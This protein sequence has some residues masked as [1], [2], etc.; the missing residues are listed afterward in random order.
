MDRPMCHGPTSILKSYCV[1]LGIERCGFGQMTPQ[2]YRT[3]LVT[4]GD[5][6][7][8]ES[9]RTRLE[10][11]PPPWHASNIHRGSRR[12]GRK[13]GAAIEEFEIV[14]PAQQKRLLAQRD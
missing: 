10:D 9:N 14:D 4:N 3:C 12:D 11:L 2:G 7:G 6:N 5:T 1:G 8:K 13:G